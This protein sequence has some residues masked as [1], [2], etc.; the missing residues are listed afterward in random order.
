MSSLHSSSV[1]PLHNDNTC[2]T[3]LQKRRAQSHA[4]AICRQAN[5]I[6]REQRGVTV[7]LNLKPVDLPLS[8]ELMSGQP[9]TGT[10]F[11]DELAAREYREVL[12]VSKQQH[13]TSIPQTPDAKRAH[14]KVLF[15]AFKCVPQTST[16]N[17][18]SDSEKDKKNGRPEDGDRTRMPF[19]HQSHDN[20][21]V[22]CLC[23]D[24][25]EACIW[26]SKKS[27]NLVDAWEP[28]KF[29]YK[30]KWTFAER[31]DRIVQTMATSKT[32]CKHLFDVG[33]VYKI[34]DDPVASAKRVQANKTLN[35]KKA[36]VM[37]RGKEA[38]AGD[39]KYTK[40]VKIQSDEE[41]EE[42]VLHDEALV[43]REHRRRQHLPPPT[44]GF[45][46]RS[47]Q[48]LLH[49]SAYPQ[50]YSLSQR[51]TQPA[52]QTRY[53]PPG[54]FTVP[55]NIFDNSSSYFGASAVDM[56]MADSV[57]TQHMPETWRA[58]S[59][60]MTG[61]TT[62]GRT[63]R[64]PQ[65]LTSGYQP[66]A[67]VPQGYGSPSPYG[68]PQP[69]PE[70]GPT[71]MPS[72][73]MASM[74]AFD[75]HSMQRQQWGLQPGPESNATHGYPVHGLTT[76]SQTDDMSLVDSEGTPPAAWDTPTSEQSWEP[77]P[78]VEGHFAQQSNRQPMGVHVPTQPAGAMSS[79]MTE[80]ERGNE[81]SQFEMYQ[82]DRVDH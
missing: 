63:V 29:K 35:T 41:T 66:S 23:W 12:L 45:Q 49:A 72:L 5:T 26:R 11:P 62:R 42:Q 17:S 15:K 48:Q 78:R 68:M 46:Q 73:Q 58:P 82:Q 60:K 55:A 10:V 71:S 6:P 13:D 37:K 76:L 1:L 56:S 36:A 61:P 59:R 57:T 65:L 75:Q 16:D 44:N 32:I 31:F 81:E 9:D 51:M 7:W 53:P 50:H 77:Y 20:N 33:Y 3:V 24:I 18:D 25:L 70:S 14:V 28:E 34:V 8:G 64:Q 27:Q 39:D 4:I 38:V 54:S 74:T 69:Y 21:L 79:D 2:P 22:E 67:Q 52:S 47:G 19:I 43:S 40:R 80:S 30:S